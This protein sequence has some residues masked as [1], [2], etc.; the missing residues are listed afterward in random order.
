[1][2]TYCRPYNH[3]FILFSPSFI[4]WNTPVYPVAHLQHISSDIAV[5]S[6]SPIP[7][8]QYVPDILKV[9]QRSQKE[10]YHC[11]RVRWWGEGG[12][13]EASPCRSWVRSLVGPLPCSS[14][15]Q[16]LLAILFCVFQNMKLCDL[17][18]KHQRLGVQRAASF[19]EEFVLI[20]RM[21][22][23]DVTGNSKY[24]G[25]WQFQVNI[26]FISVTNKKPEAT[27]N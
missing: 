1:M 16:I 24:H 22:R 26:V 14:Q 8:R 18:G 20:Y 21:T 12:G 23:F 11:V 25:H 6:V 19:S 13:R 9:C 10:K 15:A 5:E 7:L 4:F 2:N 3:P 27:K 17:R